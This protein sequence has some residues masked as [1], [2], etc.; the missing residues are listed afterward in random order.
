MS[1]TYEEL[2]SD[3]FQAYLDTRKT[4]KKS[5]AHIEFYVDLEFNL[6]RICSAIMA[7][8]YDPGRA[9]RFLCEDPV[10]REVF[11]SCF[12]HRVVCRLLYNYLRP[13]LEPTF[14][15]DS[16]SCQVGK[17]THVGRERFVHHIRSC[18]GNY[19]RR[20]FVLKGDLSGYFMSID[21]KILQQI[22][23]TNVR[24]RLSCRDT[25]NRRF[26]DILDMDLIEYLVE[27]VILR[28]PL[29]NC[30]VI[31]TEADFADIPP[32]KLLQNAPPG[33]G[34]AIGDI[35]SQLFSNVYMNEFDQF[36]KRALHCKH[37]GR[38]VDDF[39]VVSCDKHFLQHVKV[40]MEAYLRRELHLKLNMQKTR[41]V[42]ADYGVEFLG[43]VVLP[44]RV[45]AS[46]RTV[47]RFYAKVA[48]LEKACMA[49]GFPR[50]GDLPHMRSVLN[51]YLGHLQHF[52]AYNLV[53]LRLANSPLN[54]YF[55]F[56]PGYTKASFLPGPLLPS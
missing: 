49:D 28:D 22:V 16:Y 23:M 48:E 24:K 54:R 25:L 38:Y 34:L 56:T 19:T 50:R 40:A 51:S 36:A 41:I 27:L 29:K 37:Y 55:A 30:I 31:G 43:A 17:G 35:T 20:A 47:K 14:I 39:Y 15:H 32:Q 26:R 3:L 4:K 42:K 21:R 9:K 45:Y 44:F 5:E 2:Y 6:H 11:C 52:N 10:K 12:A 13:L 46:E 1:I 7:R 53:R 33:V 8:E 18:S